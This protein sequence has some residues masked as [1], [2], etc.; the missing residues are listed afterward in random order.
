[1]GRKA[2]KGIEVEHLKETVV[3]IERGPEKR[4]NVGK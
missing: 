1:M 4:V 2:E 3:G